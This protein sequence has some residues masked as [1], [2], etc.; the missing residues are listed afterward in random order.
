MAQKFMPEL[1]PESRRRALEDS[2]DKI[3]QSTYFKPL[4]QNELD[5]RMEA[6]TKN[7]IDLDAFDEE[8][9]NFSEY[10]KAKVDPLK[11]ENKS[12]LLE[13]R[14]RQVEVTG[15]LYHMANYDTG[16]MDLYGEDGELVSSRRL[17]PEER[18]QTIHSL[19]RKVI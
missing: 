6:L 18:Q 7:S 1:S 14:T 9:K 17:R 16:M 15:N 19:T 13:L 11:K 4:E 3:E 10:M 5:V 8:K 2:C 12:L